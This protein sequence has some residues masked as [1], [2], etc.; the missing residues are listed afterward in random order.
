MNILKLI[1]A[2]AS[3]KFV[4]AMLW[5]FLK[6]EGAKFVARNKNIALEIVS[7]VALQKDL[8]N[9]EKFMLAGQMLKAEIV[10]KE[11]AAVRDIDIDTAIQIAYRIYK[12]HQAK[13]A[14]ANA[15]K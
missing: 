13:T 15:A 8:S 7:K 5:D 6:D 11:K 2:N 14:E 12:Q 4:I 3:V 9:S 10:D 1:F